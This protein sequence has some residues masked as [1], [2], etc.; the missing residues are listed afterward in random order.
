MG[1]ILNGTYYPNDTDLDIPQVSSMY[2]EDRKQSG[3]NKYRKDLL[4]PHMYGKKNPEFFKAYPEKADTYNL[5]PEER[6]E[7]GL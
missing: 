4:Q 6:R 7:L 2:Q 1:K 5:T 3:R